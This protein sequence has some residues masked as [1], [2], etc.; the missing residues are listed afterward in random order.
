M[1]TSANQCTAF[2]MIR[3]SVMKELK[4]SETIQDPAKHLRWNFFSSFFCKKA[5]LQMF[6][7]VLDTQILVCTP[8][9]GDY[10]LG[11]AMN[12]IMHPFTTHAFQYYD[13]SILPMSKATIRRCSI[14]K[15]FLEF[16]QSSQETTCAR[17]SFLIKLQ[18]R[19][20]SLKKGLQN[21]SATLLKKDSGTAV[22][23]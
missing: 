20:A 14:K 13:L 3:I 11:Y 12:F 23:L 7:R 2:Y 17:V 15:G 8:A 22:F 6:G 1:E 5:P 16:S 21:R 18:A 9:R 10:F 4:H 19:R